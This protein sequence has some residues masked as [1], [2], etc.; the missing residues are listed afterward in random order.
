M[1]ALNNEFSGL[2]ILSEYYK[3]TE[4]LDKLYNIKRDQLSN[5]WISFNE[6]VA[7]SLVNLYA[8][9]V[10]LDKKIQENIAD[11][12][13]KEISKTF[14]FYYDF[15]VSKPSNTIFT[16]TQKES[17]QDLYPLTGYGI[18][19][20]AKDLF[21]YVNNSPKHYDITQDNDF[22]VK[23]Q[24]LFHKSF[25]YYDFIFS[26]DKGVFTKFAYDNNLFTEVKSTYE[27]IINKEKLQLNDM[28]LLSNKAIIVILKITLNYYMKSND[29]VNIEKLNY[30]KVYKEFTEESE[31]NKDPLLKLE[32]FTYILANKLWKIDKIYQNKLEYDTP[33]ELNKVE[34]E[35][36]EK[37]KTY[38]NDYLNSIDD[39]Y[40]KRITE[41]TLYYNI[42]KLDK[43]FIHD[44]ILQN[45]LDSIQ[46]KAL[47]SVQFTVRENFLNDI[48]ENKKSIIQS[49][50]Y[51][52]IS[53]YAINNKEYEKF[54]FYRVIAKAQV[55]NEV[56]Y[57][58]D[59]LHTKIIKK[60]T[61]EELKCVQY[62]GI[63]R[64]GSFLS[65]A[66]NILKLFELKK[67]NII[68]TQISE[69]LLTHPYLTII[70]RYLFDRNGNDKSKIVVY[71]DEAIKTG[72][73]VTISHLYRKKILQR[74]NYDV[75]QN[76]QVC[77]I[78]DFVDYKK[79]INRKLSDFKCIKYTESIMP[80]VLSD[81]ALLKC[82]RLWNAEKKVYELKLID[83]K[84]QIEVEKGFDWHGFLQELKLLDKEEMLNYANENKKYDFTKVISNSI[85][86]FMI[87]KYFARKINDNFSQKRKLI[88]Y[89][90]SIEG[91]LLI[92]ITVF[93]YK[94]Q[95][96]AT[97]EKQIFIIN[98]K[99]FDGQYQAEDNALLF[100][101]LTYITGSTCTKIFELDVNTDMKNKQVS[102]F[103]RKFVIY[104]PNNNDKN[105]VSYSE[106][107]GN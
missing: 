75:N 72:Y 9:Y 51:N 98:G 102:D 99:T 97:S 53:S 59:A 61:V 88:F 31:K 3:A 57:I 80:S 68:A 54:K 79:K 5:N 10:C 14:S 90:G 93:V 103:D 8:Y 70:P 45:F 35:Y 18:A 27:N 6:N 4:N 40:N 46:N 94:V 1:T 39:F 16:E 12:T 104:N 33:Q 28:R 37:I 64:S 86:L 52:T 84:N 2:P 15:I 63:L 73:G 100:F 101:D 32:I 82:Q 78:V 67:D 83:K 17:V 96:A 19:K 77:A 29:S 26:G 106:K 92:D 25:A 69:S 71:L 41:N 58:I 24:K 81:D 20:I 34:I 7:E 50:I 38:I 76:D 42:S 74:Y 47:E 36:F 23:F 22:H 107:K 30:G 105:I 87:G 55:W 95:Y 66:L 65:H 89:A 56:S 91:K 43:K 49:T 44:Y 21:L 85:L 62:M 11:D 48:Q 13:R 60:Y